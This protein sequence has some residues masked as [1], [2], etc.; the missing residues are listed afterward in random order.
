MHE[1]TT[2]RTAVIV[3]DSPLVADDLATKLDDLSY[4][5]GGVTAPLSS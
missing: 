3:E 1:E 2:R 4:E 5:V